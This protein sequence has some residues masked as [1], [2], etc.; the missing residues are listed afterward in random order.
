MSVR[1]RVAMQHQLGPRALQNDR[2]QR[3]Q[4]PRLRLPESHCPVPAA[5]DDKLVKS[6]TDVM[7]WNRFLLSVFIMMLGCACARTLNRCMHDSLFQSLLSTCKLLLSL[8]N[9]QL[10]RV[11][12]RG[13]GRSWHAGTSAI[14]TCDSSHYPCGVYNGARRAMTASVQ[15]IC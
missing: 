9:T 6:S 5:A 15:T 3:C 8:S 10:Q 13:V 11:A 1:L 2:L 14:S 4:P 7:S 12:Q